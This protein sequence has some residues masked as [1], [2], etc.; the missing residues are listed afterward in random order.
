MCLPRGDAV[1]FE[2]ATS[3]V[4][5]TEALPEIA[6]TVA[7]TAPLPVCVVLAVNVVDVPVSGETE[8]E[9]VVDQ[10]APETLTELPYWSA[11]VALKGC[12]PPRFTVAELGEIVIDASA[13]AFTVSVWLALVMP[14]ALAVSVGEPARVSR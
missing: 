7:L 1:R 8:P 5:V 12:V 14:L 3:P 6:P 2:G 10:P 4:I 13:A 9:A 11:P